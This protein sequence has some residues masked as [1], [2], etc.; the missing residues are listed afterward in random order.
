MTPVQARLTEFT[1]IIL[2]VLIS[3]FLVVNRNVW[4]LAVFSILISLI[5]ILFDGLASFI[6]RLKPLLFI[7]VLIV[8]FNL[9]FNNGLVFYDRFGSGVYTA[10]K[11]IS[12]SLLVF[13][14]TVTT[15]P[16]RII[17]GLFFLPKSLKIAFTMTFSLIP[18]LIEEYKTIVFVQQSRGFRRKIISP[19]HNILPVV[20]PL[21]HRTFKRA[22]QLAIVMFTR[23]YE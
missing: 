9:L 11:I 8:V 2:V 18:I 20:V 5:L 6:V 4:I 3:S 21:L 13:F 17:N 1:K 16:A 7:S 22:E 14:Y 23:G 15:S 12:L 19:L 10:I